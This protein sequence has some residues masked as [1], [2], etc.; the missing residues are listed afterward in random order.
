MFF[1]LSTRSMLAVTPRVTRVAISPSRRTA[2][3]SSRPA[4]LSC[5][6]LPIQIQ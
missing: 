3:R 2:S 1:W 5:S 6:P 4:A